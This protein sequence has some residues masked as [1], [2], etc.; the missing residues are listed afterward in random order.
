MTTGVRI[1][2]LILWALWPR[3]VAPGIGP[4]RVKLRLMSCL[5]EP[6]KNPVCGVAAS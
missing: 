1:G 4:K 2:D 3:I 6:L 5:P